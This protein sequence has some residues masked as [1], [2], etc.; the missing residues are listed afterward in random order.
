MEGTTL[1]HF[2]PMGAY[3]D[4]KQQ[5]HKSRVR[6]ILIINPTLSAEGIQRELQYSFIDPL[7]LDR[8]Y[9][10]KI[11]KK[12]KAERIHR[13]DRADVKVRLAEMEDT[14]RAVRKQMWNIL[15]D[16][17]LN[18][19]KGGIGARVTAARVIIE[20]E[21][22]FLESQLNAGVFERQLGTVNIE[23]SGR[24]EHIHKMD[25]ELKAPIL[26]A[27]ENYGLIRAI[28]TSEPASNELPA[29]TYDV[30]AGDRD[31]EHV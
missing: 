4:D 2:I 16:E 28:R 30:F 9:V 5:L 31:I 26:K 10:E 13:I 20:S 17:E 12:V 24:I 14:Y 6:D 21:K 25:P 7:R 18:M 15:N 29:P 1:P 19:V 22:S 8:G 27:L 23:A 11:M 3:S